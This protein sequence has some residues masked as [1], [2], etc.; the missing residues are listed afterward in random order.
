MNLIDIRME[1]TKYLSIQDIF[2]FIS[3]DKIGWLFQNYSFWKNLIIRYNIPLYPYPLNT[4]NHL[5][6][7]IKYYNNISNEV[8][9][10][11]KSVMEGNTINLN[12]YVKKS[13]SFV[14]LKHLLEIS[15]INALYKENLNDY[16]LEHTHFKKLYISTVS[17][18]QRNY[19][20]L[21]FNVPKKYNS[22][23][24]SFIWTG[25]YKDELYLF[26]FH[27][28]YY[29]NIDDIEQCAPIKID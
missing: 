29:I 19:F 10:L 1:I 28:L 9:Y 20:T 11:I 13:L 18:K 2:N 12:I 4:L 22:A 25:I 26:L 3:I 24:T 8:N 5:K 21:E 6:L 14:Y 15:N 7:N 27:F 23:L 17:P 16:Y